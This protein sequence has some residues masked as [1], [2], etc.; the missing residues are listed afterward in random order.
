MGRRSE[1]AVQFLLIL[2]VIKALPAAQNLPSINGFPGFPKRLRASTD[3]GR[4][5]RHEKSSRITESHAG[6]VTISE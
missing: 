6:L 1:Q 3:W 4:R 2:L 5:L